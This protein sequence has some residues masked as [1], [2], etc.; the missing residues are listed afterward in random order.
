MPHSVLAVPSSTA[1]PVDLVV[2]RP[3]P[4]FALLEAGIPLTLLMDL[5]DP[6]GPDSR[7]ILQSEAM[8]AAV[9]VIDLRDSAT[10]VAS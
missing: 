10:G 7:R 1:T 2:V 8:P 6:L 4:A 9:R 5:V 3:S